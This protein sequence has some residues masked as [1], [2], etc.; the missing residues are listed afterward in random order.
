M[1]AI[2]DAEFLIFSSKLSLLSKIIN[3]YE[4]YITDIIRDEVLKENK[5]EYENIKEAIKN[6]KIKVIN[7]EDDNYKILSS[8]YGIDYG[9]ASAI[10][11]QKVWE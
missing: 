1:K 3:L 5:P 9:E 7:L 2:C 4:L 11:L 6:N 10:F 8:L